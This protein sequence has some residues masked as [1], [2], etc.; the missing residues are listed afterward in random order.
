MNSYYRDKNELKYVSKQK[1]KTKAIDY[2]ETIETFS[3][4][5]KPNKE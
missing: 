2:Y 3:E 1:N 4:N 5:L